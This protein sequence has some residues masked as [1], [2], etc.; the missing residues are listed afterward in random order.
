MG[1]LASSTF[2]IFNYFFHRSRKLDIILINHYQLQR[3]FEERLEIY[4]ID[5]EV[6]ID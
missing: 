4:N 6:L 5:I 2:Y 1:L 3:S